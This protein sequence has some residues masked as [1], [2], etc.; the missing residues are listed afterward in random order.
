MSV[1]PQPGMTPAFSEVL[2]NETKVCVQHFL[3]MQNAVSE[4]SS[5]GVAGTGVGVS[6]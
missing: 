5:L 1:T 4:K 3:A 6:S 2:L